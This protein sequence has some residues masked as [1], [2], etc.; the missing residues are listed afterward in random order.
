M[1]LE[2]KFSGGQERH[3]EQRN[4]TDWDYEV[5]ICDSN[6]ELCP[7]PQLMKLCLSILPSILYA[8]TLA[9]AR[10]VDTTQRTYCCVVPY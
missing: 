1:G 8:S 9:P 2:G 10:K 6:D 5:V 3:F 7:R 4:I